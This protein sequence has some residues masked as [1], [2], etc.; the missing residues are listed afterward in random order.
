DNS[1]GGIFCLDSNPTITGCT[2][3]GNTAGTG[4][5][6]YHH[7]SSNSILADTIVC[8]NDPDQISGTWTDDGGNTV[9]EICLFP[10][11]C[12]TGNEIFCVSDVEE[13]DCLFWGGQWLGEAT[14]CD[15][16][17]PPV[18]PDP[19]GACCIGGSCLPVTNA[20]C[21][22]AGGSYAGDDVTCADAGCPEDCP[23]D[24]NADGSI[25]VNDILLVIAQFG[26]TCP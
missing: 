20:D 11:A 24:A 23:V 7:G 25:D 26:A 9:Q 5:G 10:G 15:E 12:C 2:I 13:D 21:F 17:P 6:I 1:G 8:G 19:V 18:E 22:A 14:S 16:C 3:S 4:G